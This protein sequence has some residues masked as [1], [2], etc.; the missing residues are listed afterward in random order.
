MKVL[1]DTNVLI[2]AVLNDKS[3]PNKILRLVS[4]SDKYELFLTSQN[5][6]EFHEV[7][8]R[9]LPKYSKFVEQF[10]AKLDYKLV[11]CIPIENSTKIR[12]PKDQPILNAA[13]QNKLDVVI[14]GDKDFLCLNLK[15]PR[16]LTPA[17]FYQK[18]MA[19]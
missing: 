19:N 3:I 9:K 5:I 10:L 12:D 17:E 6:T 18:E 13:V 7:M 11:G 2:S 4:E 8:S 16:C 1:I 14:T 15:H